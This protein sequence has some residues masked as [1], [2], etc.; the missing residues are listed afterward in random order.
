MLS[1]LNIIV[2]VLIPVFNGNKHLHEAIESILKQEY[3]NWDMLVINDFGSDDGSA[4]T[5]QSYAESDSRIQLI[6]NTERLGLAESLNMGIRMAKG[7]Y[8]A[9]L[10]AD[11]IAMPAR[12]RKQVEFLESNPNIAVCGSWQHHFGAADWIHKPPEKP[13]LCKAYT[14]F[15]C[16]LCHSTLMLRKNAFIEN[17]LFYDGSFLIEDFELWSRAVGIVNFANIPEVLG[18]Y[19]RHNT[20][21]VSDVKL[22]ELKDDSIRIVVASLKRNLNID[23]PK[24]DYYLVCGWVNIFL[25]ARLT[26]KRKIMLSRFESILRQIWEAN[27]EKQ[28]YDDDALLSVINAKWRWAKYDFSWH[29]PEAAKTINSIFNQRNPSAFWSHVKRFLKNNPTFKILVK[30][31]ARLLLTFLRGE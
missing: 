16:H 25:T 22:Q 29:E 19:R 30:K 8:I 28:F 23:L 3:K 9:R 1:D 15:H 14:L 6:Q 13:E 7:K 18:K 31:I 12:L 2:T 11:D 10:D 4:E 5:V 24:E 26:G 21:R 27:K 20:Q 17:N